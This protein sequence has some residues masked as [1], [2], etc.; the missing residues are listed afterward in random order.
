MFDFFHRLYF[1]PTLYQWLILPLMILLARTCD[2]TLG[3]ARV[4][5][6]SRGY[7]LLAAAGGFIEILIWLI[8][9]G[10][11][12]KNLSNPICYIA[13]ACGFALGNFIGIT[14]TEKLSLGVVLIRVFT[15][16]DASSLIE[17]LKSA[18][19]G[20]TVVDGQGAFGPVKIIFTVTPRHQVNHVIQIIKTYNPHAFYSVEE[21]GMVTE[22]KFPARNLLGVPGSPLRSLRKGK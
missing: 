6:V 21:I 8:A 22:G 11:I 5:F 16:R 10:Q 14:L 13:Y 4:I 1:D 7:R 18:E 17:S 19:Y 2:V 9:I 15:S 12:M 20:L 3:T